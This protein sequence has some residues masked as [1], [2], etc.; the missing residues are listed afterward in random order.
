MGNAIHK[1][2]ILEDL[3]SEPVLPVDFEQREYSNKEL[4]ALCYELQC[5][6]FMKD[7]QIEADHYEIGQLH[8][9]HAKEMYALEKSKK[10]CFETMAKPAANEE[11]TQLVWNA[12]DDGIEM[13]HKELDDL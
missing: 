8:V 7:R 5:R 9:K 11:P 1:Y 4:K 12:A 6:L 10:I 3:L 2:I 13:F